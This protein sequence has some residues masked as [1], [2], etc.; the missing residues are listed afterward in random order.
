MSMFCCSH[1]QAAAGA[2]VTPSAPVAAQPVA[3]A[4]PV[5]AVPAAVAPAA[6]SSEP[7]PEGWSEA[8]DPT[9][10]HPY[11]YNVSTGERSWVRPQPAAKA[12][13]PAAAPGIAKAP[14]PPKV[15]GSPLP[16][17]WSEAVAPD[18]GLPY[19]FNAATGVCLPSPALQQ[20]SCLRSSRR[21]PKQRAVFRVL[22]CVHFFMYVMLW[23]GLLLFRSFRGF[24][25]SGQV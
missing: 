8:V 16:L 17:G 11:W 5:A 25:V 2:P 12:P 3:S 21:D 10:N 9:Y 18:T 20:M 13:A 1:E 4:A 24:K 6:S 14:P 22:L 23:D 7:L 19:Y 15:T